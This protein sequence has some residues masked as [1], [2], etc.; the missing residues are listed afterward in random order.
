M[1]RSTLEDVRQDTKA[2]TKENFGEISSGKKIAEKGEMSGSL[3]KWTA[4]GNWV[5]P[6]PDHFLETKG[7]KPS[8]DSYL[9]K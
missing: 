7:M 3:E 4:A 6:F 9:C 1:C 5:I 2:F 8:T